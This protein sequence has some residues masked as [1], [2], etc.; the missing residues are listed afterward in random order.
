MTVPDAALNW[1]L[2]NNAEGGMV[3]ILLPLK[4]LQAQELHGPQVLQEQNY[5]TM[6]EQIF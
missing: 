3:L 2:V 5:F 4:Q 1:W 6:M